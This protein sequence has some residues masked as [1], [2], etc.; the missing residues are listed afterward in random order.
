MEELVNQSMFSYFISQEM[1]YRKTTLATVKHLTTSIISRAASVFPDRF[2]VDQYQVVCYN[3]LTRMID[4]DTEVQ[5]LDAFLHHLGWLSVQQTDLNE[6]CAVVAYFIEEVKKET[7]E[8][9]NHVSSYFDQL[10]L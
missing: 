4:G 8:D 6:V 9:V 10:I 7:F 2:L 5:L 3:N 1:L